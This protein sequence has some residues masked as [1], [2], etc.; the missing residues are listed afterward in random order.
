MNT[1]A[2]APCSICFTSAELAA[3]LATTLT[4][5]ALVKAT[6]VSSSAFFIE[7]AA[8][9]VRLASCAGACIGGNATATSAAAAISRE[10]QSMYEFSLRTPVTIDGQRPCESSDAWRFDHFHKRICRDED[11][12][13]LRW[14]PFSTISKMG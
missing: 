4:P 12:L 7:A 6:S 8:K 5:V 2:G 14:P 1:S 9:T 10:T 3:Y 13:A 11:A